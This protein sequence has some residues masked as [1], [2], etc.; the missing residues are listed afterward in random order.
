MDKD[1]KFVFL[2]TYVK[3]KKFSNVILF[4]V[5]EDFGLSPQ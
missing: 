4:E 5:F 3:I 1:N 2:F